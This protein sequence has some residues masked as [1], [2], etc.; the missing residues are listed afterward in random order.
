MPISGR[1][2][3]KILERHGFVVSRQQ[4]SH[5]VLTKQERAGKKITVV[6]L[7]K[8]LKKGTIRGI[9]KLAGL[10]SKLFGL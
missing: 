3:I 2:A 9:A 10:D 4:G 5:V 8:E 6:P 7:H 1:Q